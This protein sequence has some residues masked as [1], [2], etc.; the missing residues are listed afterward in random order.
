[1]SSELRFD[2]RVAVV[3]G[4]GAGLGRQYALLLG[5]RGAKVVVNDLGGSRS[6]EGASSNTADNVVSEIKQAG[7][8]AVADYNSVVEG[9]KII[10]TAIDNFG[11]IDILIN[12]AGIL[13]DKSFQKMTKAEWDIIQD[14]HL[15]GAFVTTQAA[16]EYFR[17]QKYGRVIFTSS[18]AGLYGNFGQANYSSAKMALVGLCNTL[19]LEGRKYNILSNVIVPTAASRLTEDILPPEL[20]E[21]LKPELIAPVVVWLCHEDCEENGSIIESAAGWA[22]KQALVRGKGA[23]LR[24][25]ITD[26]VVPEKVRDLWGQVVNMEGAEQMPDIQEVT[27]ALMSCLEQLRENQEKSSSPK[28]V[29][30][31]DE[32]TFGPKDCIIYALGI[33]ASVEDSSDLKYLYENHSDFQAFP[34]LGLIPGQM[35]VMTSPLI[36]SAIPNRS[37]DLSQVLH[38]EQ[39][40]ELYKEIPV[41]EALRSDVKIVDV[42]DKGKNALIIVG[43]HT[44]DEKNELISYNEMSVFVRGEGGF[45]GPSVS[46]KAVSLGRIPSRKPDAICIDITSPDQAALYRLSGDSNPLHIDPGFSQLGGFTKPILHGLCTLG[47]SA[48]HVLM[49]YADNNPTYFKSIKARFVKPFYPGDRIKTLMWRDGNRIY[50]QTKNDQN[51]LIVDGGFVEL[52]KVVD[53]LPFEHGRVKLELNQSNSTA[54]KNL[55]SKL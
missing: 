2:N 9:H 24:Y 12:N 43:A 35:A 18:N 3:T 7:G 48:R 25:K 4:A 42:L 53:K 50:F 54:D 31:P 28:T 30:S 52:H 38:G 33:G 36:T 16:W 55:V 8:I 27:L 39:Y 17:N 11:R 22:G 15:K 34:T 32:H 14:V 51:V 29:G 37:Y 19:S 47:F 20:F 6:G 26:N 5:K 46:S 40:L 13:R 45:G 44:Y 1:M 21:Q 23:L 10:K 41:D 49:R